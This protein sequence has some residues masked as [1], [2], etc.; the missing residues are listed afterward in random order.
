MKI[1]NCDFPDDI[2]YD[3]ENFTWIK[4]ESDTE[5]ITVGIIP[6]LTHI[7]G[8][9]NTIKLKKN[10]TLI[11]KDRSIGSIESSRY[12]TVIRS[13]IKGEIVEIN[14]KII[15]N[16]KIVNN[17]PYGNGWFVRIKVLEKHPL[18]LQEISGCHDKIKSLIEFYKVRCFKEFPDHEMFEIGEECSATLAK[19][20]ELVEKISVGEV[21]HLVSDDITADIELTRWS[22]EN[23]QEILEISRENRLFHFLIKKLS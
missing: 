10:G 14:N 7:A 22:Q 19:L 9:I 11:E 17:F 16:P 1:N 12:F 18:Q 3:V 2:L 8:K 20:D 13:S 15:E 23:S 21:V 5:I 6:I 4:N